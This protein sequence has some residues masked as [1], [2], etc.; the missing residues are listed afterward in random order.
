[1]VVPSLKHLYGFIDLYIVCFV[2]KVLRTFL[3]LRLHNVD[4]P[5]AAEGRRIA[6]SKEERKREKEVKMTSKQR[7]VSANFSEILLNVGD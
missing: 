1:M 7:R 3:H 6:K 4:N 5:V 2:L